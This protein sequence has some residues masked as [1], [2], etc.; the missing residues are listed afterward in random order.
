VPPTDPEV[1]EVEVLLETVEPPSELPLDMAEVLPPSL[2]LA[3][4][5]P[6]A[7]PP[8]EPPRERSPPSMVEPLL[9]PP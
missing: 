2:E 7:D 6:V 5:A 9:R 8:S 3:I 4:V 1:V